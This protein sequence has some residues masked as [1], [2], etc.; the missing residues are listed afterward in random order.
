MKKVWKIA[1]WVG[2]GLLTVVVAILVTSV[3]LV[4][5]SP[6]QSQEFYQGTVQAVDQAQVLAS[7]PSDTLRAGWGKVNLT[8]TRPVPLAGYAERA[9]KLSQGVRD[10][11][12]ARAVVLQQ[13]PVKVALVSLDM[14]I[15]PPTVAQKAELLLL[16]LGYTPGQLYWGATHT[17]NS[18]GGW[19]EKLVGEY[20]AGAYDQALVD[21][22]ALAAVQA[23]RRAEQ[24]L[25]PATLAHGKV[26]AG[27]LV[28][29][30]LVPQGAEYPWAHLLL[31]RNSVGQTALLTTFTAH[32]TCWSGDKMFVSNDYPGRLLANLEQRPDVDFALFMAGAVGSHGP[33][34]APSGDD[35][36]QLQ[37]VA[38]SLAQKIGRELPRLAPVPQPTLAGA[39]APLYLREPQVR[40][41]QNWRVR[42]WVF[43]ALYGGYPARLQVLRLGPM[44]WVGLPCDFSGELVPALEAS[45]AAQQRQ[46]VVTSFNGGYVGYITPDNY[47]NHL[48]AYETRTMNWFGP[49]NADYFGQ[50][51]LRLAGRL[52]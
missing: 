9:G 15:V 50:M 1:T 14:L 21:Q 4:D 38:D 24:R 30:R 2:L 36:A 41:S 7:R 42:P 22:V 31:V 49:G 51:A 8:P 43:H 17:H 28:Y 48:D 40:L 3:A 35:Q 12:F 37:L 5:S 20:F 52:P 26:V 6:Y 10:S 11:V 19:G 25:A 47:Y 45:L 34:E 44:V 29:N 33:E 39:A 23:V 18:L 13:G 46:L 32:A 16:G 27:D